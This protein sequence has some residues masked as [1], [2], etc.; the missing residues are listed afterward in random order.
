MVFV[1][2]LVCFI[3][4]CDGMEEA[5]IIYLVTSF[6]L[7]IGGII[8]MFGWFAHNDNLRARGWARFTLAALI[9][10]VSILYIVIK[11]ALYK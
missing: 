5:I 4:L 3:L 7:S 2:V 10:P 1:R 8:W 6:I 9:R 11:T